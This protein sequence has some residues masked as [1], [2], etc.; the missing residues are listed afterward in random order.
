[1]FEGVLELNVTKD[2][3]EELGLEGRMVTCGGRRSPNPFLISIDLTSVSFR[4]GKKYYE[5]VVRC[6]TNKPELIVNLCVSWMP[7]GS[8]VWLQLY[9]CHEYLKVVQIYKI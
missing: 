5:R 3:Y 6:F 2:V 1:M 8:S 7:K 9:T 4:P